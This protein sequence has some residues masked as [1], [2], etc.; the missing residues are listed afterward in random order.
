ME[1]S[2]AMANSFGSYQNTAM[3]YMY[4]GVNAGTG[5]FTDVYNQ[6]LSVV[7]QSLRVRS[8]RYVHRCS[9]LDRGNSD[10]YGDVLE[11]NRHTGH[12]YAQRGKSNIHYLDAG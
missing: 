5:T 4:D 12:R 2:T 7:R 10:G 3:I 11:R 9:Y 6:I 8:E 1:W